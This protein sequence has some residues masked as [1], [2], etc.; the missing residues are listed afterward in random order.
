MK[1]FCV[2]LVNH[3]MCYFPFSVSSKYCVYSWY[4][5]KN[6][7][8]I[9]CGI[10]SLFLLFVFLVVKTVLPAFLC[11][12]RLFIP[13]GKVTVIYKFPYL[14]AVYECNRGYKLIGHSENLCV[15]DDF[16]SVWNRWPP[17]CRGRWHHIFL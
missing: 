14:R 17:A 9:D 12:K 15:L 4:T 2:V 11:D 10:H 7:I 5:W 1:Y 3:F 8:Y 6:L 16:R 13:R